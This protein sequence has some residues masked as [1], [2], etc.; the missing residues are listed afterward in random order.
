MPKVVTPEQEKI[1][2]R[3]LQGESIESVANDVGYHRR[4]IERWKSAHLAKYPDRVYESKVVTDAVAELKFAIAAARELPQTN[5]REEL[6]KLKEDKEDARKYFER[7]GKSFLVKTIRR[8]QDLPEEAITPALVP[9]YAEMA[10]KL[11]KFAHEGAAEDLQV[12][13]LIEQLVQKEEGTGDTSTPKKI[14]RVVVDP[15]AAE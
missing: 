3:V 5:L 9:Q 13:K 8:L 15:A 6:Q 11:I 12:H 1:V 7:L 4:T 10:L 2:E 14:V